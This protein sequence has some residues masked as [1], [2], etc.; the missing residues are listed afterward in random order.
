L[1]KT[2]TFISALITFE[3]LRERRM[4]RFSRNDE[5]GASCAML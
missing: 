1:E 3:L 4:L 2:T 5:G